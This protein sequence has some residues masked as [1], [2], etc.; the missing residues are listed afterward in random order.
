VTA[1]P[2]TPP[3]TTIRPYQPGD[4]HAILASFNHV[5]RETNGE[6]Y[7]DRDLG[8]WRWQY[9]DNP[10]G[11]RIQVAVTDEGTVAAH[12]GGAPYRVATPNGDAIFVHIIDS[13]VHQDFRAGLKAPGLFVCTA[14]PWFKECY[15]RRDAVAYGFPVP[16][17][18]R[19]G[20]RY[21]YYHRLRVVNYL[22]RDVNAGAVDPPDAVTVERMMRCEPE[23]DALFT[24]FAR[25]HECLTRR[26]A[27]YL[28]WRYLAAPGK[29]YELWAARRGGELQGLMACCASELVPSAAV[30]VDWMVP[31]AEPAIT[32]ALL[33]CATAR[34]RAQSRRVLLAVFPDH[35]AEAAAFMQRGFAVIPSA[36]TLERRLTYQVFEHRFTEAFLHAHWFY[37]L[38][39]S[40][41]V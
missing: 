8:F 13:F 2:R 36:H 6:G 4:E 10:E 38:G 31:G 18:E 17:A 27:R 35:S 12:Y 15:A 26:S 28:S 25:D 29:G 40:D 37:T 19:I 1:L 21:L 34:A 23:V 39:D 14:V 16:R 11:Y 33:A 24:T 9:L 20:Q 7:V 32:D 5:F 22:C 30:L 3:P 41:L